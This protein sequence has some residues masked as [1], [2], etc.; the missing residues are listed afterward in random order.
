MSYF[1]S[2]AVN[3]SQ[4][5]L[6][7]DSIVDDR[8]LLKI[9]SQNAKIGFKGTFQMFLNQTWYQRSTLTNIESFELKSG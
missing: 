2:L 1:P 6:H 3:N 9:G 7:T 5:S 8:L 4:N